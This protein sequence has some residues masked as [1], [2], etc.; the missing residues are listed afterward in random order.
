MTSL[1]PAPPDLSVGTPPSRA[2]PGRPIDLVYIAGTHRS[3]GTAL[4]TI[5][6]SA[7]GVFYAGELYRFPRPI[8]DPGDPGRMCSCG[9]PVATCVFWAGVRAD[10]EAHPALLADLRKGQRR[11]EEWRRFPATLL[12]LSRKNAPVDRHAERMGVFLRIVADRAGASTVV[13]SSYS[14]LRG[15]LYRRANLGGGRVR[16]I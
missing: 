15:I 10:A 13:E 14:P 7:A 12:G 1:P 3:G 8:F 5:L 4:G 2:D 6:S 11:F 16:F 9:S